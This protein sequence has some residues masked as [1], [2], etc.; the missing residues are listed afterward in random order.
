MAH[1]TGD[2]VKDTSTTTGTGDITVSG[3]APTGFRTLST[4]ATADGDT[5]FLAIVGGAEWET[6]LATRVSANVYTRTTILA[7]SNAG[8]A[9]SFAAGTKDVFLTLPA[10]RV[11]DDTAYASS[12]NGDTIRPPSKN[13]V[14]DKLVSVDASLR[15]AFIAG[16]WYSP[17][18]YAS[19]T[20][21]AALVQDSARFL[22]FVLQHAITISDL[23]ARITTLHAANNIQL[24][25]Y[26]NDPTTGRPTGSELAAT[27]DITT[28][29][30]GTVSADITGSDV[31]LQPGLYWMAVNSSAS[32]AV[33]QITR[34]DVSISG[35]F[36]GATALGTVTSGGTS[37]VFNLSTGLSFGT[38]GDL[39]GATWTQ[40]ATNAWAVVF[41]KAA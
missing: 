28:A 13:A 26:A 20:V 40:N 5:L 8:S 29:S 23:G 7:S 27:G 19:Y 3:S 9:V 30:T 14:Y 6:S 41:L 39:T 25:I 12:W 37:M 34:G 18:P 11:A 38:W 33:C 1:V 31:T 32:T 17:I 2:R 22:P 15:P 36:I 10:A 35:H 4:V 24:A 16:N 21:G